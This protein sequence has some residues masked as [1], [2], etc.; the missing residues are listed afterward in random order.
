MAQAVAPGADAT[1]GMALSGNSTMNAGEA[2][3]GGKVSMPPGLHGGGSQ[4]R[5]GIGARK[6]SIPVPIPI[7][8]Q[9]RLCEKAG[10]WPQI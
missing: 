7:R 8:R 6:P 1:A 10:I 5:I 9:A 4:A 3:T 2:D